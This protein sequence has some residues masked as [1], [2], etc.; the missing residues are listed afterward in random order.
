MYRA[1]YILILILFL[2]S[3]KY[4][5]SSIIMSNLKPKDY[6]VIMFF[7]GEIL[8]QNKLFVLLIKVKLM[9]SLSITLIDS[10]YVL[11]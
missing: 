2:T 7:M 3:Y 11:Q 9:L 8:V 4:Y 10:L 5:Y 1:R 6:T